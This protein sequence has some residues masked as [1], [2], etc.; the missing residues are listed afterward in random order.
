MAEPTVRPLGTDLHLAA[1]RI[2]AREMLGNLD[3]GAMAAFAARRTTL[4]GCCLVEV[5]DP[6]G[7]AA[8]RWSIDLGPEGAAAAA[9]SESAELT[10]PVAALSA[11]V[12]GGTSLVRLAG[13]GWVDEHRPGAVARLDALLH[14]PVAPWCPTDF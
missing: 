6:H 8:G 3:D 11:A 10:L 4:P 13:V 5:L 1:A 12:L 9:T 14:L 7:P 2:V